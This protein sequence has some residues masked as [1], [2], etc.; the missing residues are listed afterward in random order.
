MRHFHNIYVIYYLGLFSTDRNPKEIGLPPP[1]KKE[2]K[3]KI[4]RKRKERKKKRKEEEREEESVYLCVGGRGR[5]IKLRGQECSRFQEQLNP[6]AQ[7]LSP[8]CL[9]FLPILAFL[10]FIFRNILLR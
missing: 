4:D 1:K 10:G 8:D 3:R 5:V 6:V 9:C 7:T 2:R